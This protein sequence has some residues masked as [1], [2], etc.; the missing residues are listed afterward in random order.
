MATMPET[1]PLTRS[2]L[3]QFFKRADGSPDMRAIIAFENALR[4]ILAQASA[5]NNG[6]FVVTAAD[7]ALPGGKVLTG[8]ANID[9]DDTTDVILD[10]TDTAV[11]PLTY[12][13]ATK[14]ISLSV[15]SKGRV[16]GAQEYALITTNVAEGASLYFT[17]AR[18]RAAFSGTAPIAL[19]SGT[20]AISLN[21]T[22]VTPGTYGDATHVAQ[23]TVDQKGRATAATSV[24]ITFPG[25]A[26]FTGT[27]AY[28]NFEFVDGLCVNAS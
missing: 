27:G 22:A 4:N 21:D 15:D 26:G 14:T 24:A 10:L 19:D 1:K 11:V 18:A 2:D 8:S 23:V 17:T 7:A 20:G 12:G 6:P 28:V 13:S 16:T 9:V 25:T 3:A 5:I